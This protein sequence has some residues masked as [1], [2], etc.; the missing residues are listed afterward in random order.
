MRIAI[1][2]VG[3]CGSDVHYYKHGRIGDFVVNEP[4]VLGHEAAGV[5]TAI[6]ASVAHLKVGDR[7]CMEPGI[8]DF[9]SRETLAGHY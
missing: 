3:I 1:K 9:A 7:V 5:V 6:G 8:P 2:T 4:M